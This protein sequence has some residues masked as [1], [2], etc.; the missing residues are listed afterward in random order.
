MKKIIW[1]SV[2]VLIVVLDQWTKGAVS[3]ELSYGERISILPLFDLTLR[4]NTGAAFSFLSDAGGWQRWFFGVIAVIISIVLAVW[5]YRL[6]AKEKLLAC[7]LA[8]VLGG[9]VG[10]LY[11]RLA[12]GYVVDFILV[13]YDG[14]FF[15]AFNIADSA[16]SVGA[17]LLIIEAFLDP[18]STSPSP[19]ELNWSNDK[20]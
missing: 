9:A 14:H 3:A 19:K 13:H 17:F 15:P 6:E 1:Y 20:Y 16:I 8:L 11:D 5:I 10:N 7:A 18:K 4:H 12:L 2:A